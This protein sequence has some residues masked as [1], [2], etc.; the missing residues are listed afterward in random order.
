MM[1]RILLFT[2]GSLILPLLWVLPVLA[3]EVRLV[4]GDRLTGEI[5]R[6][7]KGSLL[8]KTTYAGDVHL[9]WQEVVCITSDQELTFRLKNG[10]IWNGQADC[11]ASGKIQ[12]LVESTDESAEL[13]LD[14]LEAINPSPPPPEV[15]YKGNIAGGGNV[16]RGNT[17]ETSANAS[18]GFEARSKRHRLTLTGKYNYGETDNEITARNALGRIKYDFFLKKGF[19][20]YAHARFDRDDFQDIKLR[21]IYGLGLGYQILDTDRIGLFAEAGSSYFNVNFF[22]ARDRDYVAARE[23]VGFNLD[24]IPKR[25]KFFHLHEF[26]YSLDESKTYFL[27][28]EQG[29][30]FLLFRNF[31][32]NI[33]MDFSYNSQPAPGREKADFSYIGTLG[34]EFE[35]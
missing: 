4:N 5:V 23:S 27:S 11:P 21:G 30:R 17:R 35:F 22:E 13:S 2:W 6:M 33:Q 18:A 1:R 8:L 15:T 10:E 14:E 3:D 9:M 28:S 29:F 34:Y 24:I 12:I 25:F 7:E 32:A 19:Y 16:S 31:F 20:T 26:Y